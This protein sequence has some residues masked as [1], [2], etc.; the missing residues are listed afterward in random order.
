[1]D[2]KV[3]KKLLNL[4]QSLIYYHKTHM[5]KA[6]DFDDKP[7]INFLIALVPIVSQHPYYCDDLLSFIINNEI[8]KFVN[9]PKELNEEYIEK[10]ISRIFELFNINKGIH[11]IIIPLQGSGLKNDIHFGDF[12]FLKKR[13]NDTFMKQISKVTHISLKK[14]I[15]FL[16][17]TERSRS[18]DFLKSNILLV[19]I[20]NQ[21]SNVRLRAG[22]LAEYILY[23]VRLIQISENIESS[24]FRNSR[25]WQ[26]ENQHIAI[27]S[28]D[29]WRCGHKKLEFITSCNL[30]FLELYKYQKVFKFFY[31]EFISNRNQDE[32]TY[33]FLNAL[34][35]FNRGLENKRGMDK[36]LSLLLYLTAAESLLTDNKFEK[37]LRLS[38]ILPRLIKIK[39]ISVFELATIVKNLYSQRNNFVHSG[40]KTYFEYEDKS[41]DILQIAI[42]KLIM[43]YYRIDKVCS[44]NSDKARIN[45]WNDYINNIFDNAIYGK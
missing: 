20:Q 9:N 11:F 34:I 29:S 6:L 21:T 2:T 16:E 44:V 22:K 18:K 36:S 13:D 14:V 35:L 39:D 40:Q 19:K 5:D 3:K 37:S 24:I 7:Y 30:D 4:Y 10:L 31:K 15:F 33:K 27:L 41:L 43:K 38:G 26:D 45:Q 25:Y 32:L 8:E 42:A 17:H 23:I 1:M 28:S 12:Y